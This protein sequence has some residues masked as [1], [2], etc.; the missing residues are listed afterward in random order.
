[1][2]GD[3]PQQ[4]LGRDRPARR[5]R[6]RRSRAASPRSCDVV[7]E[8]FKPG[9][10]ARLGSRLR[11]RSRA[12]IPASCSCT[13]PGS[14]RP[15]RARPNPASVR[16]ARRW[17]ASATRPA[18]PTGRRRAPACRSATRSPVCSRWSARWPRSTN[19][20]RS[21]RGQEVD[22]AIY[23]AV[24]ALMESTV[25]D[26]ELGGVIRTRSGGILR[27]VAP[28][29]AYPTA[30]RPR[31]RDRGQRRRGVRAPVRR[32]GPARSRARSRDARSARRAPGSAR[33][34]DRG[35]DGD[36]DRR[37]PASRCLRA[38]DVP[39]GLDQPRARSRRPIRTSRRAR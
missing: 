21:G 19:G 5:P 6:A 2:A 35:V 20:A 33:R 9:T 28:A 31:R 7:L 3:R 39:V 4:A 13:S 22:V 14:A 36:A 25:A 15:G 10:L 34:R 1:M 32:D 30:R 17:A 37:R 16:S 29:N 27:D 26:Y 23:E 11:R 8:N 18:I 12:T 38:H 24:M